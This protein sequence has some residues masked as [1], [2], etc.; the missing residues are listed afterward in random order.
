MFEIWFKL[1]VKLT[2]FCS[3]NVFIVVNVIPYYYPNPSPSNPYIRSFVRS[4]DTVDF[5]SHLVGCPFLLDSITI[6]YRRNERDSL[7]RQPWLNDKEFKKEYMMS[8][9]A[10]WS[11]VN[12]IKDYEVFRQPHAKKQQASVERQLTIFLFSG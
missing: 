8:R 10:F 11:F 5:N 9:N 7:E 1:K 3:H 12:M 6:D 4:F 2:I